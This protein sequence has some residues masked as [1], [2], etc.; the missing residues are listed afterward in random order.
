MAYPLSPPIPYPR[1]SPI[2]AY[3]LS[4]PIPYPRL[5][6]IPAYPHTHLVYRHGSTHDERR[7][8]L[9][10]PTHNQTHIVDTLSRDEP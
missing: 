1:L 6:P 5:S 4:P 2:P 3:P 9:A 10:P 7:H 8:V